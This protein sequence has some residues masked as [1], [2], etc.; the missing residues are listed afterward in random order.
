MES[1]KRENAMEKRRVER[2]YVNSSNI[3]ESIVEHVSNTSNIKE[4]TVEHVSSTSNI[5]ENTV[6]MYQ[7][8]RE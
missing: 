4:N 8:E 6:N 3:K 5:K 1:T 7:I 2:A